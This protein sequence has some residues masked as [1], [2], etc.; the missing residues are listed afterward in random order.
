M[1][2]LR[3]SQDQVA[4]NRRHWI[5]VCFL[6][7]VIAL[8]VALP[9]S[10]TAAGITFIAPPGAQTY[11]DQ[12]EGPVGYTEAPVAFRTTDTRPTIAIQA[13][14]DGGVQL[15]CHF[16][17]VHV[18]QTCGGPGPGC[19][20]ICGS[21]Q[22]A[23]PLGPDSDQFTRGHFLAVDLVDADGNPIV[24]AWVNIDVDTTPPVIQL[25]SGGGVLITSDSG[26]TPL[27]PTF[28]F[29]VS[30]SNSVGTNVDAVTCAWGLAATTPAFRPCGSSS[31]S[32]TFT[33]PRLPARHVLYRLQVRAID[34][35][36]RPST[37]SGVYD[38]VACAL[39]IR[40]PATLAGL[41][42]SGIPT[43]LR[44]DA[45]RHAAVAV[46]AFMVNGDRSTSPRGAAANNPILGQYGLSSKTNTFTVSRRLRLFGAART[47]L[48]HARSLGLVVAAAGNPDKILAGIADDSLSYQVLVLHR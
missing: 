13:E 39:S 32:S 24:S 35:F 22:P 45:T 14:G 34:D 1:S 23:A 40:R 30:D 21:F 7:G 37:A 29:Q 31:G 38:P 20:P 2:G 3:A 12:S 47:A 26:L 16:D 5:V 33:T 44:C 17:D 4:G 19:A 36:G 8:S 46:Y 28:T 42:S 18:T 43:R 48:R 11:P 41:L 10:A 25:R 27:R 9:A 6:G 15:Q